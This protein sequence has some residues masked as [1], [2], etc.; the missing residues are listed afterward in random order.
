MTY[1]K[2]CGSEMDE[3]AT[4]CLKCGVKNGNGILF[5]RYCGHRVNFGA[6]ICVECGRSVDDNKPQKKR[7]SRATLL[8]LQL[9]LGGTGIPSIFLGYKIRGYILFAA[10][11]IISL[12]GFV[13][14]P[15]RTIS[16]VYNIAIFMVG[17]LMMLLVIAGLI[18][19]DA[20]GVPFDL[21]N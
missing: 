11:A 7:K 21:G 1:C 18:N 2:N 9:F 14:D 10:W 19:A 17:R 20:D 5:C 8:F 3:N 6:E 15:T 16:I 12:L 4:V 13:S